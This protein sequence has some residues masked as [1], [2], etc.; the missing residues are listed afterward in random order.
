M[1]LV[2]TPVRVERLAHL[3][4]RPEHG[5]ALRRHRYGV[6]GA[7]IAPK[8]RASL[9]GRE[10][11]EASDLDAVASGEGIGDGS[12]KSVDCEFGVAMVEAGISPCDAFDEFR[13]DHR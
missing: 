10:Y 9:P 8:V 7:G 4:A 3:L 1:L 12:E 2:W 13:L 6:A 11:S 5:D